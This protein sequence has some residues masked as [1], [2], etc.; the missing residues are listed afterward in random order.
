MPFYG[1]CVC[2]VMQFLKGC[3]VKKMA[4][5]SG[6][7]GL[8]LATQ[9]TSAPGKG[10]QCPEERPGEYRTQVPVGA[11]SAADVQS[12]KLKLDHPPGQSSFALG[13]SRFNNPIKDFSSQSHQGGMDSLPDGILF[14]TRATHHHVILNS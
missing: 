4:N 1:V 12:G 5:F 11:K 3:M 13:L 6:L 8:A 10:Y 9:T 14:P 2:G 7:P